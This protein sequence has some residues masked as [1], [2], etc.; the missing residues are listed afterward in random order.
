MIILLLAVIGTLVIMAILSAGRLI[1]GRS[2]QFDLRK[3]GNW[4]LRYF[5]FNFVFS[6]AIMY[7]GEPALTGPFAGWQWLLWPLALSCIG[8]LFAFIAPALGVL[9]DVAIA[10]QGG[11]A[12][13]TSSNSSA[14]SRRNRSRGNIAAGI[15]GLAVVAVLGI[16]APILITIFTTWFDTNAKALAAIP[17]VHIQ[18]SSELPPTDPNHVV[19]VSQNVAAYKGQQILGSTGQNLGS[20]YSI[21]P[22]SYTLQSIK[23][24][25]Y[26]VAPL[27]YNNLFVNLSSST[28]PGFVVVDAENPQATPRLVT[29]KEQ[30]GASIGYLPGA[31][32]NQDLLRHVYLSGYTYGRLFDPTL[33]LDDNFKPYWTISLMQPIRGY[34]GDD[35]REVLIVDAHTGV[36]TKYSPQS[37][38]SWVDRVLPSDT[39]SQYLQW[40][41]L[42]HSAPWFNPSGLGQQKPSG[43]PQLLYN[44]VDQPVWLIPM[45]SASASDNSS[46]GVFLFDTHKNEGN[47]YPVSGLGIGDNVKNTFSSTHSN[48]KNYAVDSVQLYQIYNTPTWV[49]IYVQQTDSGDIFQSVGMVDARNLNGANVQFET[50]LSQSLNDYQQWLTQQNVAGS[51]VPGTATT[52]TVTGK[53][54][55]ISPVTQGANVTYYLQIAG[56]PVL[57]KADLSL[58][59]KLPLV[60]P[61]DTV[62]G[63]YLNTGGTLVAFQSFDDQN[64]VLG[65]PTATATPEL[66]PTPTK[67]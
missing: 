29:E 23:H 63:T 53:V 46:T 33:E 51:N 28:T 20:A 35:L 25:L 65:S 6:L 41:G 67:K 45:T 60:Q 12:R 36:I 32:L 48:I 49:A 56:Q 62:T 52:Q 14:T 44:N 31:L 7:F 19:L 3:F 57:F 24:H 40:W 8:N 2:E 5:I 1:F 30:A 17:Q 58:S 55:R 37:V 15:F 39:V 34:V 21:D 42:Y 22:G 54:L 18:T 61:G 27:S 16:A 38:P 43:D 4:F 26:Y 11:R 50:T 64:I 66:M 13:S 10:S 9:E 59:Q 47:F